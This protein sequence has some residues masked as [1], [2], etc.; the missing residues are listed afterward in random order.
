M[1]TI[2][3]E[4]VLIYRFLTQATQVELQ[5][6]PAYPTHSITFQLA[7]TVYVGLVNDS[8]SLHGEQQSAE[9]IV[10]S[11]EGPKVAVTFGS[12]FE[13][14]DGVIFSGSDGSGFDESNSGV[15]AFGFFTPSFDLEGV[16]RGD[17]NQILGN[18]NSLMSSNFDAAAAPGFLTTGAAVTQNGVGAIPYI[19]TLKGV[20]DF[21]AA[22]N[23]SEYGLFTDSGF[24]SIPEGKSL[25]GRV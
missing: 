12:K 21:S 18:F 16:L 23:A 19:F 5:L 20:K 25:P 3:G 8:E 10:L 1:N 22:S 14:S 7:V 15:I 17:M 2:T 11:T 24:S 13:G 9:F 6:L 4:S